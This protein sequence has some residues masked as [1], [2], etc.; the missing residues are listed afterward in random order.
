MTFLLILIFLMGIYANRDSLKDAKRNYFGISRVIDGP[1]SEK[2][3]DM[4]RTLIHGT[5]IHGMQFLSADK[6]NIPTLYYHY[7]GGLAEVLSA[8]PPKAR[9]AAIGLG[10]GT[11]A[12]Y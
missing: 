11:L 12:V 4:V 7:W 9:F 2:D 3:S 8:M 10:A 6:K 5:T 1:V